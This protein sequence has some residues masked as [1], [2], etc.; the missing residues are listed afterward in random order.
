MNWYPIKVIFHEAI[1]PD[2]SLKNESTLKN[3]VFRIIETELREAEAN[4][5]KHAN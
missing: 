2:Q 1:A 5:I 3:E 4:L